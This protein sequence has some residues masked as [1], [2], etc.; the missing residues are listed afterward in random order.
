MEKNWARLKAISLDSQKGSKTDLMM[1]KHWVMHLESCYGLPKT[2]YKDAAACVC[3]KHI[4]TRASGFT[5]TSFIIR[6][7]TNVMVF[8]DLCH[9]DGNRQTGTVVSY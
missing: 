5:G 7:C 2:R 4:T 6:I 1:K 9:S 3:V 8:I